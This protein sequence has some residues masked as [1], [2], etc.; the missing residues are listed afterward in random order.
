MLRHVLKRAADGL[1]RA[2]VDGPCEVVAGA[3][4]RDVAEGV[5]DLAGFRRTRAD[6]HA[7]AVVG[8]VIGGSQRDSRAL[9]QIQ[10]P[11]RA[12]VGAIL[13]DLVGK[14]AAH[15]VGGR[16]RVGRK[17][18]CNE[19]RSR[20]HAAFGVDG[21]LRICAGRRAGRGHREHAGLNCQ[22][23]GGVDLNDTLVAVTGVRIGERAEGLPG[24]EVDDR[25]R[26]QVVIGVQ[27]EAQIAGAVSLAPL[28]GTRVGQTHQSR[29]CLVPGAKLRA[30]DEGLR[31]S[32]RHCA[33]LADVVAARCRA[34]FLLDG[35]DGFL[36]R[37]D[38][39]RDHV[40]ADGCAGGVLRRDS[41]ERA[42]PA[43]G[44]LRGGLARVDDQLVVDRKD[45]V[46]VREAH[47]GGLDA[48]GRVA[49]VDRHGG[50]RLQRF[51]REGVGGRVEARGVVD[52]VRVLAHPF[53]VLAFDRNVFIRLL[54][55]GAYATATGASGDRA[56]RGRR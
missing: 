11:A 18:T 26:D 47:A 43:A 15:D 55:S 22:A 49:R 23:S 16:V 37:L 12:D 4:G 35:D 45:A 6:G 14:L 5:G 48:D 41:P 9:D 25:V 46:L 27:R 51:C 17:I 7:D 21:D 31:A 2:A 10:R 30:I 8:G 28:H 50:D 52:G 34:K 33:V 13:L 42:A 3:V 32:N 29:C 40:G 36:K 19:V 1:V 20:G 54:G 56:A 44:E 38:V 39:G 24:R 53:K